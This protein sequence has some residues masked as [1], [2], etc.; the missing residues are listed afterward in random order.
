MIV[1]ALVPQAGH[2][3]PR[4]LRRS[5]RFLVTQDGLYD[6]YTPTLPDLRLLDVAK[7]FHELTHAEGQLLLDDAM[8]PI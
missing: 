8:E 6:A 2:T 7:T 4:I 5:P 1:D 3:A